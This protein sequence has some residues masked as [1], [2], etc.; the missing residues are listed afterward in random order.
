[1]QLT[2]GQSNWKDQ[3]IRDRNHARSTSFTSQSNDEPADMNLFE[4]VPTHLPSELIE[5]LA[6][7][8]SVRIERIVST[9]HSTAPG[10]WYDQEQ[11]EWVVVLKGEAR[12][13]F[14]DAKVI[15]MQPGDHLLI[16]AHQRHRVDWTTPKEP[17]IWLAIFFEKVSGTF[18]EE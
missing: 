9:G 10:D 17:T 3:E 15:S 6:E 14:S 1:M 18:L 13:R 12:L 11:D 4:N 8:E 5:V 2:W 7:G 16:P